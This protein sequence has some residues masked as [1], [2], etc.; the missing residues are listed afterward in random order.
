MR[1]FPVFMAMAQFGY[2]K[3][4]LIDSLCAQSP[5]KP[6]AREYLLTRRPQTHYE[7]SPQ[8]EQGAARK[9][10]QLIE[11]PK[12]RATSAVVVP[13]TAPERYRSLRPRPH[14]RRSRSPGQ[15]AKCQLAV[16]E[17]SLIIGSYHVKSK[18][19]RTLTQSL[20]K[21]EDVPK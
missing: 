6:N 1:F 21:G 9:I 7:Y 14:H 18:G 11:I 10:M 4:A 13:P 16:H 5:V 19:L 12:P 20:R 17:D 2:F 3:S 15:L 8:W